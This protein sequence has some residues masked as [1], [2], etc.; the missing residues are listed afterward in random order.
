MCGLLTDHGRLARFG[1]AGRAR[2]E[3]GFTLDRQ[4]QRLAE[5]LARAAG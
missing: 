2:V 5:L 3:A 1:A 4:A